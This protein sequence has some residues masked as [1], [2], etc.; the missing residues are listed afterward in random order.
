MQRVSF[1]VGVVFFDGKINRTIRRRLATGKIQ[2]E[3]D[4][5]ELE[6]LTDAELRI[7]WLSLEWTINEASLGCLA[8]AI[9]LAAPRDLGTYSEAQ[10]RIARLRMRY[11]QGIDPAKTPYNVEVWT[12]KIAETANDLGDSNPPCPSSVQNWWRR[13]RDSKSILTLVPH[14]KPGYRTQSRQRYEIFESVIAQVYLTRQ[15]M[16]K[17]AVVEAIFRHVAALNQ[18][19]PAEQHIRRPSRATIYRWLDDLQQ[20][21]VDAAREGAE[22]ARVKY[23]AAIGSVKVSRVLERIEIDHTPLDLMVIDLLTNLPLGRPWL[24]KAIDAYS[25]MVIGFYISFNAPSS[26]SVLQCLRRVMLPKDLWLARFPEVKGVWPAFGIPDLI[27]VDNG[28]DLHADAVEAACLEMGVE[29]LFCGSKTPQHKASIERFFRTAN[30]GLIHR[31]PGTVFSNIDE[32]GDYPSEE[33]AV[34]DMHDL[35]MLLTKWVVDIYNVTSHRGINARPLDVWLESA[36]NRVI[37]VPLY[38][39]QLEVITGIPAKRTLFHYGIEL[40]GL[41]YN[42]EPLQMLRHR[43]GQNQK[44]DLKYYEESV[45]HIHVFDPAS[46]EFIRVPAKLQEY[47]DNLPRAVHRLVRERARK[48]FGEHYLSPELL[49]A[50][51]EIEAI[52]QDA[53]K[54]KKMGVRKSGAGYLGHDSEAIISGQDP[55]LQA[56]QPIKPAKPTPPEDLPSGLDDD[57]PDFFGEQEGDQ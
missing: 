19:L 5:G 46:K 20:D 41:Q 16:P 47:A 31:L 11:I 32:R 22:A 4:T 3:L 21:V 7:R 44:V 53:I 52:I 54:H 25:R 56:R 33:E 38:P 23:R 1:K 13:F 50:R 12:Q 17:L 8:N 39:Q 49:Q 42:S 40:D 28:P 57:L 30:M 14:N 18:S 10:Q 48:R 34:I 43:T 6:N 29:I 2:L 55:L 24:T 51:A 15:K 35:T 26:Y 37:E 9:Y 36:S 27:A 45:G